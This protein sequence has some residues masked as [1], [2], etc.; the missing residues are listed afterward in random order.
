MAQKNENGDWIDARGKLVPPA[1][2]APTDRKKDAT[3]EGVVNEA[4][5]LEKNLQ[6]LKAK[7]MNKIRAYQELIAKQ[8]GVV[9]TGKGNITLTNF[10]GDKQ[11]EFTMHDIL[12]FD[13]RIQIAKA[14]ID[15]CLK[16]WGSN[17]NPN[18]VVVVDQAFE[19]DKQGRINIQAIL[20][21]RA[22]NIK[23]EEW[24]KA[25]TIINEALSVCGTRQ[26]LNVRVRA[27]GTDRFRTI[28]LNM[29]SI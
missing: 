27:T 5:K 19:I 12:R 8:A 14:L 11:V 13:E 10:S 17:A 28:N 20:K 2:V 26:Y 1:Y 29:S 15:N 18:L 7:W 9:I 22:L 6:N 25:M 4:L 24:Q 23:D 16:R 21:L 3:V